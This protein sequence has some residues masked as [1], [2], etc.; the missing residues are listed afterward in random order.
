MREL[1]PGS[2][3]KLTGP[4]TA[5]AGGWVRLPE[6]KDSAAALPSPSQGA[7]RAMSHE[8]RRAAAPAANAGRVHSTMAARTGFR[9]WSTRLE[10][11]AERLQQ[12]MTR[13]RRK[14]HAR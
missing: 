7:R 10:Q 13:L 4:V 2:A 5:P 14:Y 6:G 9:E 11:R 3:T 12:R 8:P 1:P